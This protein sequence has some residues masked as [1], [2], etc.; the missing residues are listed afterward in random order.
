MG[1]KWNYKWRE[2]IMSKDVENLR[3]HERVLNCIC[4]ND[5]KQNFIKKFIV[6]L[7]FLFGD[8][9][10]TYL[11]SIGK[12]FVFINSNNHRKMDI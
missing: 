6:L 10:S 1:I 2:N 8:I 5:V 9:V 3:K 11:Q 4:V 12:E 7:N